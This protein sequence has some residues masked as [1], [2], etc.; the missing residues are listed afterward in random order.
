MRGAGF[1]ALS[2]AAFAANDVLMKTT[3]G[4]LN[5]FQVVF[6]RGAI[7][8]VL[9]GVLAWWYGGFRARIARADAGLMALRV[10]GEIG[11]TMCFLTALFNMPVANATAII[12]SLPLAVT[13]AASLVLGEQVGWRRYLAISVGFL[14]VL[15]IVRPGTDGFNAYALYALAAVGFVTLRDLVTRHFTAALPSSLVSFATAISITVFGGALS[16]WQGWNPVSAVNMGFI[17][18]AAFCLPFAYLSG[19]LA[20]RVGD[21]AFVAPTRYTVLIWAIVLGWAV[22]GE[23]PDGWMLA[24]GSIIVASGAYM[25]YRERALSRAG[26]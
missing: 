5:L 26:S 21:V 3:A 17:A 6:L 9:L 7:A 18:A 20:M 14:G 2:M 12:L 16:V 19:V 15:V 22:L 1:M 25:F 24:G 4:D 23:R 10:T 8:T 13:L 11:A